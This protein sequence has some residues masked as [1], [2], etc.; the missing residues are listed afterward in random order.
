MRRMCV[1]TASNDVSTKL[2]MRMGNLFSVKCCLLGVIQRRQITSRVYKEKNILQ[3]RRERP[4][5]A[6]KMKI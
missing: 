1:L 6:F 5:L 4:Y 2:F 3:E